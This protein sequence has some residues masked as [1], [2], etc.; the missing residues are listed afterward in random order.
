MK[1]GYFLW[2]IGAIFAISAPSRMDAADMSVTTFGNFAVLRIEG[3]I[4]DGDFDRFVSLVQQGQ[5]K[6]S[7]VELL[8]PGGDLVEAMRIGRAMRQLGLASRVPMQGPNKEPVCEGVFDDPPEDLANCS[9]A[10]A[11]FFMHVGATF[12]GGTYLAVHRPIFDPVM[13]ATLTEAE[14][15]EQY[16]GLAALSRDY[17]K[18]MDVPEIIIDEVMNTPSDKIRVL[19]EDTVR[20]HFWGHSPARGEW[21][22][23]KCNT[24]TAQDDAEY[25]QL[26]D[27]LRSMGAD[28]PDELFARY[29]SFSKKEREQDDCYVLVEAELRKST[30]EKFFSAKPD[31]AKAHQFTTWTESPNLLGKRYDTLEGFGEPETALGTTSLRKPDTL[32]SP[33]MMVFDSPK[34]PRVVRTVLLNWRTSSDDFIKQLVG[35]LSAAFGSASGT[36]TEN[37]LSWTS[38]DFT[39]Q[40][41]YDA[42]GTPQAYLSLNVSVR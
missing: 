11:A 1:M 39:A 17:L 27:A 22:R 37:S 35:E 9:A 25:K 13:F 21:L 12:R 28:M 32:V 8:S 24:F 18:E 41:T 7:S 40:M 33:F 19:S 10:S 14:A 15:A 4:T 30:F 26:S 20:T 29:E 6:V 36:L 5:G 42:V 2:I 38:Q 23:A 31:E 34:K 3:A 16:S